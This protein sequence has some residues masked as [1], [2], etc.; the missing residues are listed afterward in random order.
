MTASNGSPSPFQRPK[1][2]T[3]EYA[4]LWQAKKDETRQRLR[5]RYKKAE[6]AEEARKSQRTKDGPSA[7][8]LAALYRGHLLAKHTHDQTQKIIGYLA[9]YTLREMPDDARQTWLDDLEFAVE[10]SQRP[11]QV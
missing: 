8:Q 10:A 9:L 1:R 6:E 11:Q 4:A 7:Q 2:G 3:P 5:Q